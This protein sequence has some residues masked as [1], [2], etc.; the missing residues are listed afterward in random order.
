APG[1]AA[2]RRPPVDLRA[3]PA[4][5]ARLQERPH[6]RHEPRG[7]RARGKEPGWEGRRAVGRGE[8]RILTTSRLVLDTH[9]WLDW[10]VFDDPGIARLRNA[11]GTGRAQVC[12]D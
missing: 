4:P 11:V 2:R 9:V 5:G 8:G 10:L 12:I 7:D 3:R 1:P 6:R